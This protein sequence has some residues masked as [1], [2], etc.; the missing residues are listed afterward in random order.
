MLTFFE[1]TYNFHALPQLDLFLS[2]RS[3]AN[4]YSLERRK[5]RR[6]SFPVRAIL[7]VNG[8]MLRGRGKNI[9]TSGLS[10]NIEDPPY[11]SIMQTFHFCLANESFYFCLRGMALGMREIENPKSDTISPP[12]VNLAVKFIDLSE[13]EK[14]VLA[15]LIEGYQERGISFFIEATLLHEE[16]QSQ[17]PPP[18]SH[19]DFLFAEDYLIHN[20]ANDELLTSLSKSQLPLPIY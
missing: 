4:L 15:S 18:N 2:S 20:S 17:T 12:I 5:E 16:T 6:K 7:N 19:L 11:F 8:E 14:R 13:R 3:T 10:I 9:T 1:G